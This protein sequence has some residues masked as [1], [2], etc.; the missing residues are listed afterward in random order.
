MLIR[1][2]PEDTDDMATAVA[3]AYLALHDLRDRRYPQ[4]TISTRMVR[5]SR[6]G[7]TLRISLSIAHSY[8]WY[9]RTSAS[10]R[11]TVRPCEHVLRDVE[12]ALTGTFPHAHIAWGGQRT[13]AALGSCRCGFNRDVP[14]WPLP[15]KA[16]ALPHRPE[17]VTGNAEG[18]IYSLEYLQRK[19]NIKIP[20]DA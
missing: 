12:N 1:I 5:S 7:F 3:M 15:P 6:S 8:P 4:L 2:P 10:G 14:Y 19:H 9:A 18:A 20:S 17:I 11:D 13:G 16:P